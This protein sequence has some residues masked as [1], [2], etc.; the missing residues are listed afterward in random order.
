MNS[1]ELVGPQPMSDTP[2]IPA[3]SFQGKRRRY[4]FRNGQNGVG[5]YFDPKQAHLEADN[6]VEV[7]NFLINSQLSLSNI[8]KLSLD[9][10]NF[11]M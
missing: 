7:R 6:K 10:V 4:V 11:Y 2:F 1:D 9:M 8:P 5:Y 3:V